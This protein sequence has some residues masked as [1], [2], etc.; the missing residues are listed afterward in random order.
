MVRIFALAA[1]LLL[2]MAMPAA[3]DMYQ[4]AANASLPAALDNLGLGVAST[5]NFSALRLNGDLFLRHPLTPGADHDTGTNIILGKNAAL[6]FAPIHSTEYLTAIGYY[7]A[8]SLT[9]A[10]HTTAIG[11]FAC[12]GIAGTDGSNNTCLGIDTWRSG[13]SGTQN[14]AVG[15]HALLNAS[16][17]IGCTATGYNALANSSGSCGGN[18][19]VGANAL[20]GNSVSPSYSGQNATALG[21]SALSKFSGPG[22]PSTAVGSI[23]LQNLTSGR[24]TAL[25]YASGYSSTTANQNTYLGDGAGY[26]NTGGSNNTLV[27]YASGASLDNGGNNTTLGYN[28]GFKLGAGASNNTVIGANVGTTTVTTGNHNVLIGTDAQVDT[29]TAAEGYS[30]KIGAGGPALWSATLAYSQDVANS[31]FLGQIHFPQVTFGTN[32]GYACFSAGGLLRNQSSACLPSSLRFKD[33][34]GSY[35]AGD[36]LGTLAKLKPI[37]FKMKP[38]ETPDP[39]YER[40]QIGLSAENVAAIEPRCAVYEADGVTPKSYR[41]ECLIAVLVAAVGQQQHEIAELRRGIK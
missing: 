28:A 32:T 34:T 30:I 27:G 38:A 17:A 18:T 13:L 22:L 6:D 15:E 9:T 23:S 2:A 4:N 8:Q 37:V 26:T 7:A 35:A 25:G 11:A 3:A 14:V 5:P 40:T 29:V 19:A 10:D 21:S 16:S 1:G 39:N 20:G 31:T 12:A 33:V 41:Q 36:A 24:N